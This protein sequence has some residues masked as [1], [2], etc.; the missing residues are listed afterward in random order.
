VGDGTHGNTRRRP[1]V[2]LNAAGTAPLRGVRQIDAAAETTCAL[3]TA[4]TVRCWGENGEGGLG[5]GGT[6]DQ[7]LPVPVVTVDGPPL[8]DVTQ[9]SVGPDDGCARLANGEVRCWGSDF[10]HRDG[11]PDVQH[12]AARRAH[13][14]LA[15]S[16]IGSLGGVTA[17]ETGGDQ[18]C[19]RLESGQVLCW[20]EGGYLG[21]DT[22]VRSELPAV[23]VDLDGTGPLT[24]VSLL[25]TGDQHTCA[26]LTTGRVACWGDN[27][28]AQLGDGTTTPR[29]RPV[30]VQQAV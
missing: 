20:G 16:G 13:P 4:G 24:G 22:N 10:R 1:R 9:I 14:V 25:S 11:N 19:A 5:T 6:D 18:T 3:L 29:L 8:S 28:A 21:N 2:V 30:L 15:A 26:R 27:D 17:V 7:D 12:E 23:V